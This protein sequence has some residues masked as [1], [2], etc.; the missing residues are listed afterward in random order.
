MRTLCH[1]WAFGVNA[2][3][4]LT[5]ILLPFFKSSASLRCG[6]TPLDNGAAGIDAW[7]NVANV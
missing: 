7:L 4:R 5:T 2:C 6:H 3:L 1:M